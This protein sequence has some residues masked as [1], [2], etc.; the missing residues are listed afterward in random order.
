LRDPASGQTLLAHVQQVFFNLAKVGRS[1]G[2]GLIIATQRPADVDKRLISQAEWRF[3]LKALEPADLRVYRAY[4]LVDEIAQGLN[5][6]TGDAY[7]IGPD[8][9]RGI[10]HLRRRRSP[11]IAKAPGLANIRAAAPVSPRS[12][13]PGSPGGEGFEQG[14][15]PVHVPIVNNGNGGNAPAEPV[16]GCSLYGEHSPAM[17]NSGNVPDEEA[18][19]EGYTRDEEIQ[20][21][22]AYAALVRTGAPVTRRGIRDYLE[23]N[24]RQ[25]SRIIKPVC[26]KHGIALR[27]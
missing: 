18:E 10:F 9:V 14:N 4:G 22:K 12:P 26:D 21:I 17:G 15:A 25:F 7:V 19:Q 3:L 6:R 8:G 13:V 1:L 20:V 11:D 16:N 5:P 23:W 24:N 27:D 2:E